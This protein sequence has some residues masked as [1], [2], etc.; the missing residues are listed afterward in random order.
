M[1][2]GCPA[3]QRGPPRLIDHVADLAGGPAPEPGLSVEDEATADPGAPEVRR[4]RSCTA[5]R[6]PGGTR[7]RPRPGRRCRPKP[8]SQAAR[9]LFRERE[10][11][12]P[13]GQVAGVRH[14]A[15]L[16]V[17][18]TGRSDPDAHR[19]PWSRLR[20][21]SAASRSAPA[22][23]AATSFGP[24]LGGV[25]QRASP[26][27]LLRAL[28]TTVWIL[29]PPRSMP[30]RAVAGAGLIARDHKPAGRWLWGDLEDGAL[31]CR[32]DPDRA[33]ADRDRLGSLPTSM[34][35]PTW[36]PVSGSKRSTLPLP[37]ATQT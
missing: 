33:L 37:L 19:A 24:A 27:T 13:A 8:A 18:V 16:L 9:E 28:T 31:A 12:L 22:I 32:G 29:V 4:A 30:P 20:P 14:D 25:A 2:P 11:A 34:G 7:P 35:I 23:S 26:S 21:A 17:G 5:F 1:Q 3:L 10:R 15:G 36:V 6:R